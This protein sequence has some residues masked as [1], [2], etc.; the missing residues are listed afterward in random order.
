MTSAPRSHT[1]PQTEP[2]VQNDQPALSTGHGYAATMWRERFGF[3]IALSVGLTAVAIMVA[4]ARHLPY[5]DPDGVTGPTYVLLPLILFVAFLTDV[6]PRALYRSYRLASIRSVPQTFADV[7]RQRW[8][9][10]HIR[11]ALL[12]LGSWY[13]TYVSF[14]NLKSYVPFVNPQLWDGTLD[15]LDR[16]MLFGHDPAVLLHELFGTGWAAHFF[17][18]IY[19]AW[20]ALVPVCLAAALVWSRSVSGGSWMVTGVAVD[21]V[22]GVATYFLVPTLGPI[23]T[24]QQDFAALPMTDVSKIQSA[25]M[26]DRVDVLHN[27]FA[28]EAV[29]TIAAFASLHVGITVTV[30]LVAHLLRLNIWLRIALWAFLALTIVATVYLGWH[31]LVDAFGGIALGVA[32]AWIAAIGTGN[33]VKWR[34]VHR[35]TAQELEPVSP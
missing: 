13:L 2:T 27:P 10:D 1:R 31:Y 16:A 32:G 35:R 24:Q 7:I 30:C 33:H 26:S 29:Q 25:M 15:K 4:I 12:G 20:I 11:F 18:F 3:A 5:R 19:I 17:S 14:R 21:W 22:L 6:A 28:T 23:Y 8:P 9:A 34:P